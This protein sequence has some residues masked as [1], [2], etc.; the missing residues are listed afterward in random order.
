[1]GKIA[2]FGGSFDPIHKAHIEMAQ[3]AL[4]DF[5]LK[6]IIFI[7]A[8]KPPHKK[9][10]FACAKERLSMLKLAV[11]SLAKMSISLYEIE[12]K[13]IVYSYQTADYFQSL[14]PADEIL[15]LI[16]GDS[17]AG[18]S[19]WKNI[20]ILASKY[21]FI[22]VNRVGVKI[23]ANTRYLD[24][25][26]FSKKRVHNMSSTQIRAMLECGNEAAAD[27]LD[28]KV[29]AY[30]KEHK[31]YS[32]VSPSRQTCNDDRKL[33][34]NIYDYLLE[35]LKKDR[36]IHS[37]N[38]SKTA[39]ELAG[40]CKIDISKAQ[41]AAL[42]HDCAKYMTD[43]EQIEFF[44]NRKKF[45]GFDEIAKNAPQLIHGF[46]ASVIAREIFKIKDKDI[47]NAIANHTLGRFNMSLLEK[48][49]F[50]ADSIS[51]DRK[52]SNAKIIKKTVKS[53]LQKAFIAVMK[54]KMQYCL[55]NNKWICPISAAVWNYY[56]KNENKNNN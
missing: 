38:V 31:L 16:G 42:L 11:G 4:N 18:L 21:R 35:H 30:I 10:Q 20:D 54:N 27:F 3:L 28:S 25:C 51:A 37:I 43:K 22:A 32:A 19:S 26:L 13:T 46:S 45:E 12:K 36:F 24:R 34:D 8:Y 56:V 7:P 47:L 44:K 50:I 6:E 39:M 17:L 48:I 23:D 15:L 49:V 40:I 14:Y 2:I 55:D 33:F 41:I 9:E 53:D 5:D 52:C 29:Y 1:M